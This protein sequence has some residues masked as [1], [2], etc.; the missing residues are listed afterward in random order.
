M[1][2]KETLSEEFNS[3]SKKALYDVINYVTS[4][5][6]NLDIGDKICL[7]NYNS[8]NSETIV[9]TIIKIYD[10]YKIRKTITRESLT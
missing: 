8:G 4:D 9:K 3:N 7:L 10:K 1:Q 6:A 2:H 5:T